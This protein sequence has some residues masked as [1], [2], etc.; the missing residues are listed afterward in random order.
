VVAIPIVVAI[1]VMVPIVVVI[2]IMVMASI[3]V[4]ITVVVMVMVMVALMVEVALALFVTM[5]PLMPVRCIDVVIP[6]LRDEV[7]GPTAGV[8]FVA[9]VRPVPFMSGRYVEV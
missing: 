5:L 3:M 2:P 4:M 9:M 8:V 1:A 6:T 7:D